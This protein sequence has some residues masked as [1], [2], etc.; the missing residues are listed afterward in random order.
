MRRFAGGMLV[1]L[2]VLSAR[3]DDGTKPKDKPAGPAEQIQELQKQQREAF[4]KFIDEFQKAKDDEREKVGDEKYPKPELYEGKVLAIVEKNPKELFAVDALIW[5]VSNA[6]MGPAYSSKYDDSYVKKALA[7]LL[8]DHIDSEKIGQITQLLA[9][10]RKG[11]SQE[12]LEQILEKNPKPGVKAKAALALVQRVQDDINLSRYAREDEEAG[13]QLEKAFGKE[14][15]ERLRKLDPKKLE[16]DADRRYEVL[17]GY[18]PGMTKQEMTDLF[19]T[20]RY[21]ARGEASQKFLR[22]V[23][24]TVKEKE[25]QGLAC[26]TLAQVIKRS[27]E[28]L[29]EQAAIEKR[30][31]EAEKLF[32]LA[33][34]KYGDIALQFEGTIGKKAKAELFELRNLA[35]GKPAPDVAGVDQDGKA[36]KLADYKGKVVLLDFWSQF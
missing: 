15:F 27:T 19:Q 14:A 25:F 18:L 10:L 26:F 2:L 28:N 34:E 13:K 4:Q 31:A 6:Q 12:I 21:S 20:L 33:A 8:R 3:A 22:S 9:Y 7:M 35:V 1:F 30:N 16:E 36:F 11:N 29:K 23:M 24:D 17:K 32:E 5:I